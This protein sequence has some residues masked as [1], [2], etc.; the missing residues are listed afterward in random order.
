MRLFFVS[1][2]SCLC[3]LKGESK[4]FSKLDGLIYTLRIG[5]LGSTK[6]LFLGFVLSGDITYLLFTDDYYYLLF[7]S[8]YFFLS[9]S[10]L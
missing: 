6:L 1:V 9:K 3:L 7:N 5:E 8:F 4:S 10:F 2:S